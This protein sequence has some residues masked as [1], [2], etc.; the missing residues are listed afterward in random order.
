MEYLPDDPNEEDPKV[1]EKTEKK[2]KEF[3]EYIVDKGVVL[4][5]VKVLL[6]LKY[7]ENKPRNPIKIILIIN[8]NL[9]LKVIKRII[10][11]KK[12]KNLII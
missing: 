5:F 4:M 11:I 1:K 2:L 7:A 6:S 12:L 10:K 9:K 8:L 3:R